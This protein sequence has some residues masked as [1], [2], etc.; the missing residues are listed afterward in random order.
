MFS[1]CLCE[2]NDL[3]I[4]AHKAGM[5]EENSANFR[6]IERF[7]GNISRGVLF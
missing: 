5:M 7:S 2:G 1:S 6:R 4:S 3:T